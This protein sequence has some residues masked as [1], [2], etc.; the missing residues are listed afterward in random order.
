MIDLDNFIRKYNGVSI[1]FDHAYGSQCQ[2][3][4]RLWEAENNWPAIMSTD[5]VMSKPKYDHNFYDW[6][7]AERGKAQAGDLVIWSTAVGKYGHI[8]I[9]IGDGGSYFKSFDQNWPIGSTCHIQ[10]HNWN[11]LFGFIRPKK[12]SIMNGKTI[13]FKTEKPAVYQFKYIPDAESVVWDLLVKGDS[14]VYKINGTTDQLW[15]IASPKIKKFFGL[16]NKFR[17]TL[18][19]SKDYKAIEA[20]SVG[21]NIK[22]K[23]LKGDV[24]K[25]NESLRQEKTT[26]DELIKTLAKTTDDLEQCFDELT[27]CRQN[28]VP[29]SKLKDAF[30][31]IVERIKNLLRKD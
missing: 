26:N 19:P 8:A 30:K 6:I 16:G 12:G 25:L 21:N 17:D 31:Y 10:Q 24:A 1:D 9:C 13:Y 7:P 23:E 5:N 20:K 3:L 4:A 28:L 27:V 15:R 18:Y 14:N 29:N 2:D 22:V 11:N